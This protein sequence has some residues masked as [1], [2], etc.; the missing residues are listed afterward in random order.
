[1]RFLTD[2]IQSLRR[3]NRK[4]VILNSLPVILAAVIF[5]TV[6]LSLNNPG[7]VES[8]Y[9][10]RVYPKIEIPLSW[11]S[12]LFPFSLG[13]I[14]YSLLIITFLAGL[15]AV[16]LRKLKPG[17]YLLRIIQFVAI[18]Y[19]FFYLF[20]GYNYFRPDIESR[21]NWEKVSAD[22][23]FFRQVLDTIIL[24]VNRN[25]SVIKESDYSL[26]NDIVDESYVKNS[27]NIGIKYNG[28]AKYPKKMLFSSKIAKFGLSGYYGPY[29]S[30]VQLNSKLLPMEYPF[31]L[32]HEVAHKCG[33]ANE[34]EANFVAYVICN[35]SEDPRLKYSGNLMILLYFLNDAHG[36]H[37]YRS[38][39]K[40]IDSRA[41]SDIQF[42]RRYYKS[43]QNETLEKVSSAANDAY[44]KANNIKTG[45]KN[46]D[47]VVSLVLSGYQSSYKNKFS[48]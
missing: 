19:S 25:Y 30:E 34:A 7:L 33:V 45:I 4:S 10:C 46:Y 26:V 40:K 48:F 13:D 32:S 5:V 47:Q 11:F 17:I 42:M 38:I 18:L 39:V 15:V 6:R 20:W 1:M 16:I 35:S 8:V 28:G 43:L 12:S 41:I 9:S 2:K 44:L 22:E 37:D 21:L 31:A 27:R 29:F 24:T 14:F 36:L 3:L 23:L